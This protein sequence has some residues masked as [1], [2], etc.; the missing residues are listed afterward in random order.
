M[1]ISSAYN[2]G[3]YKLIVPRLFEKNWLSVV[4]SSVARQLLEST[5][6]L[7]EDNK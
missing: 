2:V 4:Q 7:C 3:F 5:V 6:M 1:C